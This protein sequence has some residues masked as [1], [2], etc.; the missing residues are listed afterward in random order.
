MKNLNLNKILILSI[1]S[2]QNQVRLKT[3]GS[4]GSSG[5]TRRQRSES[6]VLANQVY[7]LLIKLFN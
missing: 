1:H 5:Q 3:S 6:E 4:M 2:L 7:N